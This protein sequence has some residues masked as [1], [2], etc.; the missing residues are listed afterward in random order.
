[1]VRKTEKQHCKSLK[2]IHR[3]QKTRSTISV[4]TREDGDVK[5]LFS[6]VANVG[7]GVMAQGEGLCAPALQSG[8]PTEGWDQVQGPASFCSLVSL[9]AFRGHRWF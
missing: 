2:N 6:V 1:M 9:I 8:S 7:R 3:K 4:E 5:S